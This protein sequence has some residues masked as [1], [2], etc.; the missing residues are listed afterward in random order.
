MTM[1]LKDA[2]QKVERRL[3]MEEAAVLTQPH[4]LWLGECLPKT[5]NRQSGDMKT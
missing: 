5:P 2:D 1:D 3:L 4:R